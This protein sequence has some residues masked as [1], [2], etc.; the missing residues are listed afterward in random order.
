MEG[1]IRNTLPKKERLCGK[2]AI[3]KLL[4]KGK[5]GNVPGLRYLCLQGNDAEINRIMVSV[6]KKSFKRAVKRNLLK[7][8]IRES[9]RR[10]K[11]L[12]TVEGN[13]DILF[14]YSVKDI[15]SYEEIYSAVGQ[16]I[17]NLNSR[18]GMKKQVEAD[19]EQVSEGNVS[20]PENSED[21]L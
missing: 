3:S 6:P 20:V 8:R 17:E 1:E 13:L 19:P 2:T 15:L 7:R 16:I 5:H 12:L 4:A 14:M 9:W 10:Q 11:H 21:R 18:F